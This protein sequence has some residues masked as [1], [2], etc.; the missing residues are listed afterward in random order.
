MIKYIISII[1]IFLF[2]YSVSGQCF[3]ADNNI[4]KDTWASCQKTA[5]PNP[6][7]GNSH[8]IQYDLGTSRN[9]SETWVWNTNDP[10]KLDRGF[11][12]V[13]VDYS[14]DGETWTTWGEM[15]FPKAKG[16]AIYGGFAGPDLQ[17]VKARFVLITALSNHGDTTCT[18]LAEVKFNLL[19]NDDPGIP[20]REEDYESEEEENEES[21]DEEEEDFDEDEESDCAIIEEIELEIED[22]EAFIFWEASSEQEFF[23]IKYGL[24][25]S[26][27][28]EFFE[29]EEQELF[30]D[31]ITEY[32]GY[33]LVIGIECED[34]ILWSEPISIEREGNN[35]ISSTNARSKHV[36]NS[37]FKVFP[38]PTKGQVNFQYSSPEK[39][40]LEYT[41][42]N[43]LGEVLFKREQSIQQGNNI[44]QLELSPYP[45]GVYFFN[46]IG[47][48]T[49]RQL[50][51]KIVK[52]SIE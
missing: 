16:E 48:Q 41:I 38:N 44:L 17:N 31:D 43:I 21:E 46:V 20:I 15:N 5:N 11:N 33:E 1:S 49:H 25:G 39:E 14:D 40:V 8:W 12:Q 27:E 45:D 2:H 30:I 32:I 35:L 7:N 23:F 26:E 52:S 18:G 50:S 36:D 3:D 28:Q 6:E 24:S 9:L 42:S 22:N 19:P 29:I 10:N 34:D 37:D 47:K 4:W 51:Q 13:K